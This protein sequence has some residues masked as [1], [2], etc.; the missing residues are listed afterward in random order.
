[1]IGGT[2]RG[3]EEGGGGGEGGKRTEIDSILMWSRMDG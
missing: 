2:G 1:M 3:R